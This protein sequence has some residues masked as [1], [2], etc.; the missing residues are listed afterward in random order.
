MRTPRHIAHQLTQPV[1]PGPHLIAGVDAVAQAAQARGGNVHRVTH[2]VGKALAAGF[3]GDGAVLGGGEHGAQK[4]QHAVGVLVLLAHG[5]AH[6]IERVAADLAQGA[7]ALHHKAFGALHFQAQV[8]SAHIVDAKVR[9]KQTD[10]R[11]DGA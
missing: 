2:L 6:Q 8:A 5:L 1:S 3:A 10:E 9:I 11:A 4:Q 7:A